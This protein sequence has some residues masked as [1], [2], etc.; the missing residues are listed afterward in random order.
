M[1][2]SG[3]LTVTLPSGTNTAAVAYV[4]PS[5]VAGGIPASQYIFEVSVADGSSFTLNKCLQAPGQAARGTLTGSVDASAISGVNFLDIQ[6]KNSTDLESDFHWDTSAADFSFKAPA[7][8][9]SVHVLAY[10]YQITNGFFR[11]TLLGVKDYAG[12]AVPGA[13]NGG[14]KVVLGAQDQT[15]KQPITYN[16]VPAGFVAPQTFAI[17]AVGGS[18]GYIL[19]P[20]ATDQY[21]AV[22][23]AAAHAGDSYYF[24]AAAA[25][26]S[27][28]AVGVTAS[29]S[30]GGPVTF[31][32]PA[33]KVYAAPTPAAFPT[34]DVSYAG[35]SSEAG[36]MTDAHL[37][38]YIG[39]GSTTTACEYDYSASANALGGG[40]SLVM[41]N[42]SGIAG[43]L[44][45]PAS[46]QQVF[47]AATVSQNSGGLGAVLAPGM[48]YTWAEN[49]GQYAVP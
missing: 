46:K 47:W 5:T 31:N 48:T 40:N 26:G 19:D 34:L 15:T 38:W 49:Y 11:Q 42:L 12:Q 37:L 43:F 41:P 10:H 36:V 17:Y 13:L 7:G 33:S 23:A 24:L 18:D 14:A 22:P 35:F 2:T 9:D 25:N 30:S 4:C 21:P 6:A 28:L 29:V 27:S 16:G 45:A 32:L 39:S 3:K 1:L 8:T 44:A 20:A